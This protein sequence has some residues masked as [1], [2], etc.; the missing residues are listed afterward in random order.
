MG[1]N[2][3]QIRQRYDEQRIEA[4][5]RVAHMLFPTCSNLVVL[6]IGDRTEAVMNR[7]VG[8][9]VGEISWSRGDLRRHIEFLRL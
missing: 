4:E 2:G 9:S 3:Q 7:G 8:G 6:W 1:P 5:E